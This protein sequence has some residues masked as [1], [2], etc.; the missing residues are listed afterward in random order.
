MEASWMS[1]FIVGTITALLLPAG[2]IGEGA[3]KWDQTIVSMDAEFGQQEVNAHYP[4]TN[5]SDSVVTISKTQASCGC[6]V[7]TLEKKTYAPGESGELHAHFDIGSRVGKQRKEITVGTEEGGDNHSYT[8]VLNVE[9]PQLIQLKRRALLWKV[10]EKPDPKDCE[11]IIHTQR[12]MKIDGVALKN[13]KPADSS[14]NF[15]IEEIEANHKYRLIITPK[16]TKAKVR[17]TCFFTSEDDTEKRLKDFP[18]YAWI[19]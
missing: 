5:A 13:G 6:T 12:P 1:R 3:L 9:I 7:P 4:F 8:L 11:V 17:E 10:G 2:L 14:F 15:E 18:I 19:R 16:N